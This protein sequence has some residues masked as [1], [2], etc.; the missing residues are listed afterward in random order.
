MRRGAHPVPVWPEA[1]G[2]AMEPTA[3]R[4]HLTS[5]HK[6][7][8]AY[9]LVRRRVGG[10]GAVVGQPPAAVRFDLTA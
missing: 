9:L 2:H 3:G 6:P 8:L 4:C 1:V 7:L 5:A 10:R